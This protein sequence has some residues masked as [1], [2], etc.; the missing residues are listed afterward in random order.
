MKAIL[1]MSIAM[2]ACAGL[3]IAA[4]KIQGQILSNANIIPA[5]LEQTDLFRQKFLAGPQKKIVVEF[6][7]F[8]C[9]P[10]RQ[11]YPSLKKWRLMHPE[12]AF[13]SLNFPLEFHKD[14]MPAAIVLE[15]AR[16]KGQYERTFDALFSGQVPLSQSSLDAYLESIQPSLAKD[17]KM[18]AAAKTKIQQDVDFAKQMKIFATPT[19]LG[20]DG[21]A[22]YMVTSIDGLDRILK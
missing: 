15:M 22:L 21:Y 19:I 1:K 4:R 20:W 6:M 2:V 8:Q 3:G 17:S 11:T 14:A 16:S 9:P 13:V 10:C 7:D 18:I 12:V 5:N